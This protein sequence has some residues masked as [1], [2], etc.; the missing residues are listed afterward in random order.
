MENIKYEPQN[1][2]ISSTGSVKITRTTFFN[3]TNLLS[4]EKEMKKGTKS[5]AKADFF[6]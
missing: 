5:K 6:S 3:K 1:R 4:R 2:S